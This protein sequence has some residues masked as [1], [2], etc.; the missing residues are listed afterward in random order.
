MILG[1]REVFAFERLTVGD[2]LVDELSE[3]RDD[4]EGAIDIVQHAGVK[5]AAGAQ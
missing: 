5:I 2:S 1:G 4:C 3:P